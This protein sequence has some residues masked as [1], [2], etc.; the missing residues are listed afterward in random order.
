MCQLIFC[1][2]ISDVFWQQKKSGKLIDRHVTAQFA[3]GTPQESGM[4]SGSVRSVFEMTKAPDNQETE[5]VA[6]EKQ[7]IWILQMVFSS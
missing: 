4:S 6:S 3:I 2:V 1:A 7:D 5:L